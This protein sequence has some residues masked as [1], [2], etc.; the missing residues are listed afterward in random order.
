MKGFETS[1]EIDG[2][3]ITVSDLEKHFKQIWTASGKKVKDLKDKEVHLYCNA[4]D[5]KCYC[6]VDGKEEFR[7]DV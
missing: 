2:L 3:Q 7:F 4:N 1:F 6:V 5:K